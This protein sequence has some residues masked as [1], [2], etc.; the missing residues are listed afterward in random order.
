M[1]TAIAGSSA[2]SLSRVQV[3][4]G[5][6]LSGLPIAGLLLSAS[7]KLSHAP[8]FVTTWTEHFGYPESA[9]TKV[10][11]LE[12]L[13]TLLYAIPRT[14]RLGAVLLTGY[15]G[16]AITTHVR[17]SEPFIAPLVLG[18]LVWVGLYLRDPLVRSAT[19]PR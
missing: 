1:N 3:W 10:G 17:V 5:R 4:I 16:G 14:S 8:N 15:L 19:A 6:V 7:M 9:L 11:L 12:V 13:C 18:V 2:G